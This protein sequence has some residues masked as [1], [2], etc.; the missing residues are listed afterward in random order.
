MASAWSHFSFYWVL[1]VCVFFGLR[2][3]ANFLHAL[4]DSLLGI[5]S[6]NMVFVYGFKE[7]MENVEMRKGLSCEMD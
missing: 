2:E 1:A 6:R 4:L 5:R 3:N 7:A